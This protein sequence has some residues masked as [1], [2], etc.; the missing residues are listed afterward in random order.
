MGYPLLSSIFPWDLPWNKPSIGHPRWLW[1]RSI[2]CQACS[3]GRSHGAVG[4]LDV[5]L[6]KHVGSTTNLS[7]CNWQMI[8]HNDIILYYSVYK[9]IYILLCIYITIFKYIQYDYV[10]TNVSIYSSMYI[11]IYTWL[12]LLLSTTVLWIFFCL[13]I[14]D[15]GC[16]VQFLQILIYSIHSALKKGPHWRTSHP[17][18][19]D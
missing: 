3:T 13:C 17:R 8:L 1:T 9:Y 7:L 5:A 2:R 19:D 12:S 15:S 18:N 4:S 14:C 11:Y 16:Y 10:C 6:V